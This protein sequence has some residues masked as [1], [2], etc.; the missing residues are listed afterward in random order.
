MDT[1]AC[2]IAAAVVNSG[3][4]ALTAVDV[5]RTETMPHSLSTTTFRACDT[6]APLGPLAPTCS[7]TV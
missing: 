6:V 7:C 1:N 3:T 5:R 4:V 2:G